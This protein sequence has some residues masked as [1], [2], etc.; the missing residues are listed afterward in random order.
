MWHSAEWTGH[1]M[2]LELILAGLLVK[3]VNHYSIKDARQQ[4]GIVR[5]L[6][7]SGLN[8]LL[9]VIWRKQ[10][11]STYFKTLFV[12]WICHMIS[13]RNGINVWHTL[14]YFALTYYKIF[15]RKYLIGKII[16]FLFCGSSEDWHSWNSICGKT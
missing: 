6:L 3:L 10:S 8:I 14:R 11:Q 13:T 2:R 7:L 16:T 15:Q 5:K 4:N 12:Y 1:T 9:L